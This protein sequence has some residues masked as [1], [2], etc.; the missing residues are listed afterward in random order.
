LYQILA[1]LDE[2]TPLEFLAQL[3]STEVDRVVSGCELLVHL[4]LARR[5]GSSPGLCCIPTDVAEHLRKC[6]AAE[7]GVSLASQQL[8]SRDGAFDIS[9]V[10][11]WDVAVI[12]TVDMRIQQLTPQQEDGETAKLVGQT[13]LESNEKGITLLY[14]AGITG[15]LMMTNLS[16]DPSFKMAAV[17]LFEAGKLSNESLEVFERKLLEL[18]STGQ[19]EIIISDDA[20]ES[21]S[22]VEGDAVH[23]GGE[24]SQYLSS[25][26]C[27]GKVL[28]LL[29][30]GEFGPGVRQSVGTAIEMRKVEALNELEA[31]TRYLVLARKYVSFFGLYPLGSAPLLDLA[32]DSVY[33]TTVA[34]LPSPWMLITICQTVGCSSPSVFIP[35]GERLHQM[36]RFSNSASSGHLLEAKPGFTT[37]IRTQT[38]ATDSEVTYISPHTGLLVL[39]TTLRSTPV[40]CQRVADIPKVV[41]DEGLLVADCSCWIAEVD[42]PFTLRDDE[43]SDFI[44]RQLTKKVLR[45]RSAEVRKSCAAIKEETSLNVMSLTL[46]ASAQGVAQQFRNIVDAFMLQHSIGFLTFCVTITDLFLRRSPSQSE[47][48]RSTQIEETNSHVVEIGFGFPIAKRICCETIVDHVPHRVLGSVDQMNVHNA[49]VKQLSERTMALISAASRGHDADLIRSLAIDGAD[50]PNKRLHRR[51]PSNQRHLRSLGCRSHFGNPFPDTQLVIDAFGVVT[52]TDSWD[53]LS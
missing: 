20:L 43:L 25:A 51:G 46:S 21:K 22:S 4:G 53:P 39:N 36:P 41:N 29:R 15:T 30:C 32:L 13:T 33:S 37:I 24:A 45:N 6:V 44:L 10:L 17:T 47:D 49:A 16:A 23:F 48:R 14:D 52:W 42:V 9:D 12:H 27:L 35:F 38:T 18:N 28:E 11:S 40:F 1:T 31:T 50:D 7:G 26:I 8:S 3:L 2:R 34:L 19:D 5:S